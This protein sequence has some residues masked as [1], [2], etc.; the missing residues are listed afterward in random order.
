M[1]FLFLFMNK[2]LQPNKMQTVEIFF[3]SFFFFLPASQAR[4]LPRFTW[5]YITPVALS[6]P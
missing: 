1:I 3:F 2:L 4:V 6:L 5:G